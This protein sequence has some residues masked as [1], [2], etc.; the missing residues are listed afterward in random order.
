MGLHRGRKNSMKVDLKYL[1]PDVDRHG[2]D[3]LYVRR[4]GR[5][6]RIHEQPGTEAFNAEYAIA[7]A[8]L[9]EHA[10]LPTLTKP[11][12]PDIRTGTLAWLATLYFGSTEFAALNP[13]SQTTRRR[14]IESCLAELSD[15]KEPE[16]MGNVPLSKLEAAHL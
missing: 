7:L 16:P 14:V 2:N 1:L 8:K 12:T 5:K 3:R 9:S 4:F 15:H 6:I 11:A 13:G 10:P